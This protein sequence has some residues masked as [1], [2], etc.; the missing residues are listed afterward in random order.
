MV[1]KEGIERRAYLAEFKDIFE[2]TYRVTLKLIPSK[3]WLVADVPQSGGGH[4]AHH[5]T[6]IRFRGSAGG[7]RGPSKA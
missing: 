4:N 2:K 3:V 1:A 6:C 7:A 5:V